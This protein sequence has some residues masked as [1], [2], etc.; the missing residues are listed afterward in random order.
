V[1]NR[2]AGVSST[3]AVPTTSLIDPATSG[4]G[5]RSF[6]QSKSG[7]SSSGGGAP[8]FQITMNIQTPDVNSFRQSQ[9]QI[10]QDLTA[11]LAQA[12][13]NVGTTSKLEDPTV[14]PGQL[15]TDLNV[16]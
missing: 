4:G 2:F 3:G 16:I 5:G 8:V 1:I 13:R 10:M 9:P 6:S 7:G 14:R 11:K 15:R 12:A